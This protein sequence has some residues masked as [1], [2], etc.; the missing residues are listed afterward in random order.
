VD[1]GRSA[2]CEDEVFVANKDA[3]AQLT[4]IWEYDASMNT[5]TARLPCT[6]PFPLLPN[7]IGNGDAIYFGIETGVTDAGPFD[8]LIFD[9]VRGISGSF[10]VTWE[11]PIGGGVWATLPVT[12]GAAQFSLLGVNSVHWV[13][14]D[15]NST[16]GLWV[17]DTVGPAPGITAM[18]VRVRFHDVVGNPIPPLQGNRDIYTC[19]WGRTDVAAA[20]ILGDIPATLRINFRNRSDQDEYKTCIDQLDLLENRVVVGLRSLSRGSNFTAYLNCADEQNPAGVEVTVGTG[21]A[22]GNEIGAPSGRSAVHTTQGLG[23]TNYGTA[24]TITLSTQIAHEFY[25]I[26]H[27]YLRAQLY[28]P[29]QSEA[30]DHDDVRVRLRVQS[31]SGGVSETT[32]YRQFVGWDDWGAAEEETFKDWQ[33]LDFGQINIPATGLLKSTELPDETAIVIEIA[34]VAATNLRVDLY[35]VVLIPVDEWSGDF[36]D[37]ALEDDSGV[38]HGYKLDIDSVAHPKKNIRALVR[39]ADAS[40]YVRS[41]YQP[42]TSGPAILQAN[43]DQRLWFLTAR[44]VYMGEHTTGAGVANLVDTY[45]DFIDAGVQPGHQ[46]YNITQNQ[47]GVVTVVVSGVQPGHQIYNITQN[48]WGVVTVVVSATTVTA[49]RVTGAA[50][51]WAV[52]DDYIIICPHWRSEPWNCHSVQ[53]FANAR[54]LSMRGDR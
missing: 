54:Y 48:Q 7:P 6:T 50:Y 40:E 18:W 32:Q 15:A 46:I 51:A 14:P 3:E 26:Y 13:P 30:G 41:V 49:L 43:A 38:G 45:S 23:L 47:W 44:G 8:N 35:D 19:N 20:Q 25:G 28:E 31:G 12:D 2:T 17:A 10:N 16:G 36:V 4:H 1:V 42:V 22:F 53:L 39:T 21:T 33:L 24:L 9:L 52:G 34:S 11:Y 5:Y 37:N 27:A 29:S